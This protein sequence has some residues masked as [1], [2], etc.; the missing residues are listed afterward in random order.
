MIFFTENL[1]YLRK[2]KGWSQKHCADSLGVRS[3]SWN[4]WEKGLNYPKLEFI[5]RIAEKFNISVDS[6]IRINLREKE[7]QEDISYLQKNV[8]DV[9]PQYLSSTTCERCDERGEI[10]NT[11]K[12]LIDSLKSHNKLLQE[13][14][15]KSDS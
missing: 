3:S 7:E 14:L 15:N 9:K 5:V 6:L 13:M 2:W 4:N 12:E 11:Q 10:I 1:I 8:T